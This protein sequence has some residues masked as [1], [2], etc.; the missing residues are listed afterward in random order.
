[1]FNITNP[2]F[3]GENEAIFAP[4]RPRNA[5][6]MTSVAAFVFVTLA[7]SL[8]IN[9]FGTLR[10][11]TDAITILGQTLS[12]L[13]GQ[14]RLFHGQQTVF[15]PGLPLLVKTL[16]LAGAASAFTL[17]LMNLSFLLAGVAAFF[18]LCRSCFPSVPST[19]ALTI[20][21]LT[22]MSWVVIKHAPI[23]LTDAPYFGVAV[24][25]LFT[26]ETAR[27][28]T[29][30]SRAILLFLAAFA[31]IFAAIATRR[32]GIA[33]V[34][35]LLGGALLW[36]GGRWWTSKFGLLTRLG[37]GALLT[38][39][40]ILL[41]L[42]WMSTSTLSDYSEAPAGQG[43]LFSSVLSALRFRLTELAE[44]T[45]N[46]PASKIPHSL[47]IVF[48]AVGMALAGLLTT[49]MFKHIKSNAGLG[50]SDIYCLGYGAIMV[51]WPYSDPRFLLP[52]IPFILLYIYLGFTSLVRP[53]IAWPVL[54]GWA[55]VFCTVGI[56]AHLYSARITLSG[57]AFPQVYGDG[58]LR[59]TYCLHLRTCIS[60]DASKVN[61]DALRL[62]QTFDP[63]NQF[64][65]K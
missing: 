37:A 17:V 46:V 64:Q 8:F 26:I 65:S 60:Y 58:S 15:P 30:G 16:T 33:L 11:N 50:I 42:W 1:M 57:P 19:I 24:L 52:V 36:T 40:I 21:V 18:G 2:N 22:L 6:L 59:D 3:G 4:A 12:E 62:L 35:P 56:A 5:T 49:G 38:A 48:T 10:L 54:A 47:T 53:G 20:S 41:I 51:A 28:N 45:I 31:L 55:A 29:R 63:R 61:Q 23:P 32:V 25:S 44:V 27:R 34:P 39:G 7:A 13:D 14:G 9:A 43:D